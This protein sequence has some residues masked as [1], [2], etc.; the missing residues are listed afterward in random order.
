MCP[1]GVFGFVYVAVILDLFSRR[2]VG[3][4]ISR[5]HS[6]AMVLA[7]LDRAIADRRPDGGVIHH[8]DQGSEYRA[9]EYIDKLRGH[10]FRISM[11]RKGTPGD[12]ALVERFIRTLKQ[13]E[14]YRQH[15]AS[16]REAQKGISDFIDK[17]NPTRLHS[18]LGYRSPADY[19]ASL[20]TYTP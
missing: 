7:A 15:Y 3:H 12:N 6:S 4:A 18:A 13:E 1:W 5:R 11:S 20:N 9:S 2:C 8:S 14:V 19:E 17:Y 16:F 10:G